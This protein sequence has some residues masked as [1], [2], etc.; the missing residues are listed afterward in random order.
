MFETI[1]NGTNGGMGGK[2]VG[3]MVPGDN[4][5]GIKPDE[6]LQVI[7]WVRSMSSGLTGNE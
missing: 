4:T 6:I 2:G 1:W 7:A 3:V 5:Q